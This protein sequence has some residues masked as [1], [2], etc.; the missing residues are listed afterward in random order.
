MSSSKSNRGKNLD[1][2]PS[3]GSGPKK[4]KG[5][6]TS[7]RQLIES[8]ETHRVNTL[9]ELCR[10]ERV[11]ATCNEADAAAFQGPMTAA[12][13]YYVTSNQLLLELR[14]LTRSYPFSAD[15]LYEARVRVGGDPASNRSWNM[16]WLVL[17]K[18][19]DDG[20]VGAFAAVEAEKKEMWGDTE[21]SVDDVA[22]LAA[23]F[24]Y[25]WGRA[26]NT[27]LR[28]WRTPPTWY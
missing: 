19:R 17:R 23:Y 12:W 5:V 14:G 10:I 24:E 16:A 4:I 11:A 9:T 22:K 6:H 26:I 8:L 27:M 20:L 21:P 1:K 2:A 25:E 18:M 28:H 13:D 7:F 15:V 3:R